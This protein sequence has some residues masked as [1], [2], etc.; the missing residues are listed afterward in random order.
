MGNNCTNEATTIGAHEFQRPHNREITLGCVGCFPNPHAIPN[1][2]DYAELLTHNNEMIPM[3]KISMVSIAFLQKDE[4]GFLKAC[5]GKN[6]SALRH[7]LKKG[8]NVNLLDEDR[9]SPLHVACRSGSLQ[10]VEELVNS[11]ATI[12]MADMAGWTALH[13]AA[14]NQRAIVCH[15]LLKKGADPY[16]IF[17]ML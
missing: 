13:V 17:P 8:V 4:I 7:Y 5:A 15:L 1:Q 14:F 3:G 11:G 9:T 6:I 2:V 12:N 10:V 16:L